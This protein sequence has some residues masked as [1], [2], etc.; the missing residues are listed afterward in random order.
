MICAV[1]LAA[2]SSQR[3]GSDK[4]SAR[5]PNGTEVLVQSL[6]RVMESFEQAL[7]V[8]REDDQALAARMEQIFD[9]PGF[10]TFCAPDSALGMGHNLASAMALLCSPPNSPLPGKPDGIF[11]FLADMPFIETATLQALKASL[12]QH[13]DSIV[14]PVFQ[15]EGGKKQ[16]GHPVGFDAR[17]FDELQ[18]KNSLPSPQKEK[19]GKERDAKE[20]SEEGA[21]AILQRH[22]DQVIEIIVQ[23]QA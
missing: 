14:V 21:R 16:R 11:V 3:F 9:A 22:A 23:D 7:L 13:P 1:I 18:Q 12:E 15:E 19:E 2:G 4:R 5:L 20:K 10:N 6:A 8:L 17:F